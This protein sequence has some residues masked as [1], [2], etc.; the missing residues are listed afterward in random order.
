MARAGY[1]LM[2]YV[3]ISR[4]L[5]EAPARYGRAYLHTET[6]D[7]DTTYFIIHQLNVIDRAIQGLYDYLKRKTREQRSAEALLR[8][9]PVLSDQLNHRQVALLSHALRHAGYGYTVESHRRS[10]NITH[11]TSRTDLMR[12]VE[13]GLVAQGKR[14]RAF[15]FYAPEDLR[16]SIEAAA[17]NAR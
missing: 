8:H 4:L 13:L 10:H 5:K 7:N 11:Q 9:A 1:W 15:V 6:D 2:E 16:S 12:L 14:G 3:S 17:G